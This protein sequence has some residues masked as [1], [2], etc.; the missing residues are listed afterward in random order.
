MP[1]S[2]NQL[3]VARTSNVLSILFSMPLSV[4][5]VSVAGTINI[6]IKRLVFSALVRQSIVRCQ[7]E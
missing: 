6:L 4:N 5:Q 7:K 2:I 3:S 1:L